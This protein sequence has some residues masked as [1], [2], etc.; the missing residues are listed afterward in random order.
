MERLVNPINNM[1]TDA[2]AMTDGD[3]PHFEALLGRIQ[4]PITGGGGIYVSRVNVRYKAPCLPFWGEVVYP[5]SSWLISAPLRPTRSA[6]LAR[7][8]LWPIVS[9][10]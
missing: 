3:I 4:S 1:H 7:C 5:S 8:T 6:V 2:C 10:S 9:A